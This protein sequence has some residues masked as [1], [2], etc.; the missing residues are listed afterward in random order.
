VAGLPNGNFVVA[1]NSY[2]DAFTDDDFS[3]AVYHQLFGDP[4]EFSTQAAPE[5]EGLNAAITYS[6]DVVNTSPQLLDAN[7]SVSLSDPDSA[8]FDGGTLLVTRLTSFQPLVGQINP[9][10]DLT[11]DQF[12]IRN[13][14]A[15]AGQIG[16]SGSDVTFGGVIIG[17]I[18]QRRRVI[19]GCRS[20]TAMA[21]PAN[22]RS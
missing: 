19:S 5:L 8:N 14:G 21:V 22:R 9:P 3:G 4:T 18:V 20:P 2:A 7:G 10:D 1:Y 16:V 11:Q 17:T 12:G 13:Q 15:G 6:E